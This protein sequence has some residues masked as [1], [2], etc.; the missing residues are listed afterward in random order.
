M[1]EWHM[2]VSNI[3]EEVYFVLCKGQAGSDRVDRSI[4]PSFVEKPTI[5][6]KGFEKV[7]VSFRSEP[8][9]APDFEIGP[10]MTLVV[11]IPTIITKE[12]HRIVL[13]YVL[14]MSLDELL[15]AVPESWDSL[16][17]FVQA[18]NEAVLFLVILHESERV[19]VNI[20]VELNAWLD[21][22]IVFKLIQQGMSE[23][24]A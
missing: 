5:L 21:P 22:P 3:V 13:V 24:E 23:E 11:G 15:R 20:T 7:D 2:I 6:I 18:Q 9:Q 4:S 17:V 19:I 10:E 1:R 8:V 12:R 16:H 14:W